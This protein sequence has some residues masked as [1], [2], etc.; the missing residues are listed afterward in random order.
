MVGDFTM[1]LDRIMIGYKLLRNKDRK[2]AT[3]C[4]TT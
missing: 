2:K 4:S 3:M 1:R